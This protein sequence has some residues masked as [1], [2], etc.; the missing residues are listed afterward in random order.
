[1]QDKVIQ[2]RRQAHDCE[3]RAEQARHVIDRDAWLKLAEEWQVLARTREA[4]EG[5]Q[6][7]TAV[8]GRPASE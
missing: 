8:N 2:F 4:A 3:D 5:I 7:P 6:N 1:M